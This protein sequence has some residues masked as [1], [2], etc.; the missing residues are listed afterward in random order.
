MWSYDISK[1]I[2]FQGG[3]TQ[4]HRFLMR[5]QSPSASTP[6]FQLVTFSAIQTLILASSLVFIFRL[7]IQ[8]VHRTTKLIVTSLH[9][10]LFRFISKCKLFSQNP[11][12][13]H[14]KECENYCIIKRPIPLSFSKNPAV[15]ET[16]L[17]IPMTDVFVNSNPLSIMALLVS[18]ETAPLMLWSNHSSNSQQVSQVKECLDCKLLRSN[19]IVC[20]ETVWCRR[21]NFSTLL[22]ILLKVRDKWSV[23]LLLPCPE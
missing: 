4:S 15:S 2:I 9:L 3:S 22:S 18:R 7:V 21:S 1:R 17:D 8:F 6:C 19:N 13:F 11:H 20:A 12:F 10:T 5:R 23:T 16:Q 14:A